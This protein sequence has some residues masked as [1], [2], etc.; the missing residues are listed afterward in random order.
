MVVQTSVGPLNVTLAADD[1]QYYR[2]G[3]VLIDGPHGSI[4]LGSGEAEKLRRLL[5]FFLSETD[6]PQKPF[7]FD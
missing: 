7:T 5:D 6:P 4:Q 3:Y 2:N 1:H